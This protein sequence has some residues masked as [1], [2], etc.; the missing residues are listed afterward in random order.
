MQFSFWGSALVHKR[1]AKLPCIVL[2]EIRGLSRTFEPADISRGSTSGS[3][4]VRRRSRMYAL[5][6]RLP[7]LTTT[8]PFASSSTPSLLVMSLMQLASRSTDS[9]MKLHLQLLTDL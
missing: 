2:K 7:T 3:T 9:G 8:A 6:V 4:A 5:V 1:D